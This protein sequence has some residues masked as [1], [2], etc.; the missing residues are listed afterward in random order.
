M[1]TRI[2]LCVEV[3][4]DVETISD[5]IIAMDPP[6]IPGFS[7]NVHIV[8]EPF[9]TQ[10]EEWLAEDPEDEIITATITEIQGGPEDKSRMN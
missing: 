3:V 5:C 8:P 10:L 7:G 4:H 9:A 2:F 6:S 1:K